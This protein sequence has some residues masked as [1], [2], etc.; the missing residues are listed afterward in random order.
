MWYSLRRVTASF[1]RRPQFR[2][3]NEPFLRY[4]TR[5]KVYVS[6]CI[7]GMKVSSCDFSITNLFYEEEG[8]CHNLTEGYRFMRNSDRDGNSV[9]AITVIEGLFTGV[10]YGFI[11]GLRFFHGSQQF[12]LLLFFCTSYI[13]RPD[14]I[15][16]W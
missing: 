8:G 9:T 6:A 11:L 4:V 10:K 13:Y 14:V 12:L 15:K 1:I 3:N 2:H 5:Y 16:A 7:V